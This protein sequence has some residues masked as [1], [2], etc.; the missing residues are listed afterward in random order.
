[1]KLLDQYIKIANAVNCTMSE[2]DPIW[3]Y[4][5]GGTLSP[6]T[7]SDAMLV[8]PYPALLEKGD[9]T[10]A[11]AFHPLSENIVRGESP[12]IRRLRRLINLRVTTA[13]MTLLNTMVTIASTP[14]L[15]EMMDVEDTK[16]LDVLK[17]ADEKTVS[18]LASISRKLDDDGDNRII[19]TYLKRGGTFKG[20]KYSR[21]AVVSFPI[22]A[23]ANT[24]DGKIFGV[25]MSKA[26]KRTILAG[27]EYILPGCSEEKDNPYSYGSDSSVAPFFD[28]LMNSFLLIAKAINKVAK[29]L[30]KYVSDLDDVIIPIDWKGMLKELDKLSLEIPPLSGNEGVAGLDEEAA[31]VAARVAIDAVNPG[32]TASRALNDDVG[33]ERITTLPAKTTT[34]APVRP[35][36][37]AVA[38]T[39]PTEPARPTHQS[40]TAPVR[41]TGYSQPQ[42]EPQAAPEDGVVRP[43]GQREGSDVVIGWDAVVQERQRQLDRAA[44]SVNRY[45]FQQRQ[46][47]HQRPNSYDG[48]RSP[49]APVYRDY[50][51]RRN[52]R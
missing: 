4:D 22:M 17:D 30:Q 8:M 29:P 50:Q 34:V 46:Q 7:V 15:Q 26:Q 9:F 31:T 24:D 1:M 27:L 13:V 12:V 43:S 45:D 32:K 20:K 35:A 28:S 11:I 42:Y 36:S 38:P 10:N 44:R 16:F 40:G 25:K 21:V 2:Q 37:T 51:P 52:W 3:R 47:Q 6:V 18:L 33:A 23:A 49:A 41:P 14:K 39:R 48:A 5:L 19:R